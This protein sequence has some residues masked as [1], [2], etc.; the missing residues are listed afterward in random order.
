M[1]PGRGKL[2]SINQGS[3]GRGVTQNQS[4]RIVAL[5]AQTEQILIEA[6]RQIEF[7]TVHVI[8]GLPIGNV[9]ELRGITQLLPQFPS[10]GEGTAHFRCRLAFD[11]SQ[12]G[13]KCAAKFKLLLL[14][15]A[16][17]RQ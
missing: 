17:V 5:T 13:A 12:R 1:V 3:T 14:A 15:L 10:A 9:K 7:A 4:G 11:K 8:E 6:L 2:T 16:V